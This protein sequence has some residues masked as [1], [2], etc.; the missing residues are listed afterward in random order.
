MVEAL[1]LPD[2]HGRGRLLAGRLGVMTSRTVRPAAVR[3][4][5]TVRLVSPSG[6]TSRD[7]VAAGIAMLESWGLRVEVP[8][9]VFDSYGYL[10][11]SDAVRV[12]EFNAALR[13]PNV[14]AIMCTRGGYG[15]SRIVDNIDFEAAAADP[16][17]VAGYSDITAILNALYVHCGI[18]GVHGPVMTT[19]AAER[20][21]ATAE[22]FRRALMSP[23]P[24]ILAKRETETAVPLTKGTT[25]VTG[26]LLGGNLSLMVDAVGTSNCP[27]YRGAIVFCEEVNEEPYRIDRI[28]TQLRRSGALD[29]VSGFA[30]GQFTSCV[31]DDWDTDVLD[32]LRDRLNDF[33]VPIL[34][35][36]PFG[37]GDDPLTVPFGTE[38]TLDPVA[39]TLTAQAAVR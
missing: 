36:L 1:L 6:P 25:A 5:D 31:D 20:A 14:R 24:A 2:R 7:R 21:P 33:D 26:T 34:G 15:A 12:A 9:H 16:K 37:H 29:G 11:G 8:D 23:H 10:A 19:F 27:D 32:M 39:G 35:G 38:A 22:A 13:D 17:P 30:L 18:T 4:G 3:P 28:W